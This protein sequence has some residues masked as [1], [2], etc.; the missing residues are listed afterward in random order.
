M[1]MVRIIQELYWFQTAIVRCENETTEDIPIKRGIR[2]SCVLS[3]IHI[4]RKAFKTEDGIKI[5]DSRI[6]N[7]RYAD[8]TVLT[9]DSRTG[10][11]KMIDRVQEVSLQI[12]LE[13]NVS[14]TKWMVIHK[15]K[16]DINALQKK[17]SKE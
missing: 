7:I 8:D 4:F 11:Q 12:G 2:Q 15:R 13:I 16:S 6:S 5:N 1:A 10:L 14:Q 3:P 17:K 9:S